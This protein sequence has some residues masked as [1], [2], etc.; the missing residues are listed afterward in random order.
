MM[1]SASRP[2]REPALAR[3]NTA[4]IHSFAPSPE[5]IFTIFDFNHPVVCIERQA[6]VLKTIEQASKPQRKRKYVTFFVNDHI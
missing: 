4:I 1:S 6:K 3:P 2:S 5:S